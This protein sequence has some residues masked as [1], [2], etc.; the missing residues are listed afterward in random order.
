MRVHSSLGPTYPLSS[1]AQELLYEEIIYLI[2]NKLPTISN[3]LLDGCLEVFLGPALEPALRDAAHEN[4]G[5]TG[6]TRLPCD[7]RALKT[8][9]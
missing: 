8:G 2:I 6:A 9:S 7:R 1:A 4:C 3:L 5:R